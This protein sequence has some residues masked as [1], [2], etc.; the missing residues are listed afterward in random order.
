[1]FASLFCGRAALSAVPLDSGLLPFP[2]GRGGEGH[3]NSAWVRGNGGEGCTDVGTSSALC[4]GSQAVGLVVGQA[5]WMS[6][7]PGS[8][9]PELKIL[10]DSK[11]DDFEGSGSDLRGRLFH[12]SIMST[13]CT[14]YARKNRMKSGFYL[15]ITVFTGRSRS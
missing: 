3:G 6:G 10:V 9:S 14:Q 2:T 11:C 15:V 5:G 7:I 4:T 8:G 13:H 12:G 1:V